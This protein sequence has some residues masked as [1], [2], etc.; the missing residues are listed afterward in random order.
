MIYQTRLELRS[1]QRR[2]S[3]E[4]ETMRHLGEVQ[5]YI[6]EYFSISRINWRAYGNQTEGILFMVSHRAS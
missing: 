3:V 4:I 6:L 5:G 2:V 1:H